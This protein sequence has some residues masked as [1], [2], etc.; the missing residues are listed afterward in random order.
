MVDDRVPCVST[1]GPL[2]TSTVAFTQNTTGAVS[3]AGSF[4]SNNPQ[5]QQIA[6]WWIALAEKAF[7]KFYAYQQAVAMSKDENFALAQM[8]SGNND[9]PPNIPE[10]A[11][12]C[13]Y[14]PL[15]SGFIDESLVDITGLPVEKISLVK[16]TK[17]NKE[18]GELWE[19][20]CRMGRTHK[21]MGCAKMEAAGAGAARTDEVREMQHA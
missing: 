9:S 21:V 20:L 7:A 6:C 15:F 2:L 14:A 3:N 11:S 10:L 18:A 13:G 16:R 8:M 19:E 4:S 17:T 1:G 12:N 5:D